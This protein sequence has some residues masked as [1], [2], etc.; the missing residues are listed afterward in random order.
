M[1][2][3]KISHYNV[4]EK[5]GAGGMGEV[6]RATDT[7]LN[8]DVALKVLPEE[9]ARDTDRMARFKREAQVL[10]S[11]NHPNIA[12]IYGLE[13]PDGIRCLVLELVEGPTLAERIAAGPLP[14]KE[15]LEIARQIAEALEAAHEQGIIHRDLKPAN[16]KVKK[17]GSVKVLDFGLAKALESP[18]SEADIA[19]SPTLSVAAT[20]AGVILGTAAYMSPEQARG[21]AVDKRADIWAFGVV[22]YEMLAGKQAFTG[23][24]ISDV[25]ASV[26]KNDIGW[27]VLPAK[28]PH[29]IR[30]LLRRCLQGERRKRLQAIGEA[31][32][33]IEEY[34]ED[35]TRDAAAERGAAEFPGAAWRRVLPWTAVGLLAVVVTLQI[36]ST[37]REPTNAPT[38]S[39]RFSVNLPE[40]TS[41][42]VDDLAVAVSPEGSRLAY[43]GRQGNTNRV[44]VRE[45]TS[46]EAE[47]LPGTE[48]ATNPFFSP[49]GRWLG[50]FAGGKLK[51]VSVEGGAPLVLADAQWGHGTWTASDD[52]IFTPSYNT[53]LYRIPAAGGPPE[54]LTIPNKDV[55]TLGHWWPH[56]LPDGKSVLFTIFST[57]VA[58]S[59]IAVLSLETGKLKVVLEGANFASYTPTGHLLFVRS[60]A[61]Y[62]VP[63][64]LSGWEITGTPVPVLEDVPLNPANGNSQLGISRDG[65]MAYI[66]ASVVDAER[67]LV[68]V[69]R[70][71]RWVPA[72]PQPRRYSTPAL[73]PDGKQ[74]AVTITQEKRDIWIYHWERETLTRLS[75][76][77]ANQQLPL[78]H[79]NGDR[80]VFMSEQPV[81]DLYWKPVDGSS[82]EEPLL[83][84]EMDKRPYS[85]SS[86]GNIL[87]Y[88]VADPKTLE[89]IWVLPLGQESKPRPF[90]QTEFIESNPTFSPNSRW[91]A[92]ESNESGRREIYVQEFPGPGGKWLVS[93]D[94][95][96]TPVWSRNGRELF[97]RNGDKMMVVEIKAGNRFSA[98]SPRTLFEGKFHEWRRHRSFDV[99]PDGQRFIMVKVPPESEP[100][101][102]VVILNWFDELQSLVPTGKK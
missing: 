39:A 63:F 35:P 86:R 99:T 75:F 98:G 9:F 5:L 40:D 48:G 68:W 72:L 67:L 66:P 34:L 95:G 33:T 12:S 46:I 42:A 65:T 37:L 57:P 94:G 3:R 25:L 44:Y 79:P 82:P 32:I 24:T 83:V 43:V 69:D 73:S 20:Q 55:G 41:L 7:K 29:R 81:W 76:G 6:Y 74:L 31:R 80:V 52:I 102:L 21:Q 10:A 90:L 51:K 77:A 89:D 84:S 19:N 11:L 17:D 97:Y 50:F 101:H 1:I 18:Q 91:L 22:L 14:L 62:A 2:G 49:D 28:L 100:R 64:D 45:M 71:G 93:T 47:V 87:A 16:V 61:L 26:L 88:S 30:N 70:Q 59:K 27:E 15:A 60:P 58:T 23:D 53:G 36:V 54:E 8:R 85:F 56:A 38:K 13:E 78:W 96:N 92:Y 4:T